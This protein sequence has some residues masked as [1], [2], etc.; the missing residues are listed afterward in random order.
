MLNKNILAAAVAV[1][2]TGGASATVNLDAAGTTADPIGTVVIATESFG[3]TDLNTDGSLPVTI[4]ATNGLTN[5]TDI[6]FEL[7]FGLDLDDELYLRIDLDN[8]EFGTAPALATTSMPVIDGV[9]VQGGVGEDFVIF[10]IT[11][12]PDATGAA[13]LGA[14]EAITLTSTRY[15]TATS[16]TVTAQYRLY[17]E[18]SEAAN[19]T[20]DTLTDTDEVA[21][22]ELA[23]GV[24]GSF[25]TS[26]TVTATVASVFT[27]FSNDSTLEELG[28]IDVADLVDPDAVTFQNIPY[29]IGE[30][31]DDSTAV[32]IS[33]TGDFS[34][35]TFFLSTSVDCSTSDVAAELNDAFTVASFEAS[36]FTTQEYTFCVSLAEADADDGVTAGFDPD[37]DRAVRAEY[38][39]VVPG[40]TTGTSFTGSVGEVVYDTTS[41]DIPFITTF[42]DYN[43]RIYIVNTSS[44][45]ATYSFTFYTEEGIEVEGSNVA[46]GTVPANEVTLI[47]ATE[48][49]EITGGNRVAAV[50]DV[51]LSDAN[52]SVA[53]QIV[54]RESGETDT[55]VLN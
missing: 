5:N 41:V 19:A 31:V 51:E 18:Q 16:G 33:V 39:V 20:T 8:A 35:G 7:G 50:L 49:V 29:D 3:T 43:Q 38:A 24:D 28:T 10:S 55:I 37:E 25:T 15:D 34:A 48:L 23:S 44:T 42:A 11:N 1:A 45:E 27:E 26:N 2:F 32:T 14:G 12:D 9:I 22:I 47:L 40:L 36:D 54:S 17:D 6:T 46:E 4:D 52:V 21:F 30:L 13:A 53:T